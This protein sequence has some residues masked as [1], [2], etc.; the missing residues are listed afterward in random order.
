LESKRG[1][2]FSRILIKINLKP[3]LLA[4]GL[5]DGTILIKN[6]KKTTKKNFPNKSI[7]SLRWDPNS[8]QYLLLL[9]QN[10]ELHLLD[11]STLEFI[12]TFTTTGQGKLLFIF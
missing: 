3:E 2:T 12:Q 4:A 6:K 11:V 8:S 5:S 9:F 10:F 1:A 7:Q